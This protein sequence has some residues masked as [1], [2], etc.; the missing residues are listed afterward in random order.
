MGI[1]DS[2]KM[3]GGFGLGATAKGAEMTK[4]VVGFTGHGTADGLRRAAD[5]VDWVTSKAEEQ[6]DNVNSWAL[7]KLA[8]MVENAKKERGIAEDATA[9]EAGNHKVEV[10]EVVAEVKEKATEVANKAANAM[11][12]MKKR[13]SAAI[14]AA[15]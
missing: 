8:Q 9:I 14:T 1:F 7:G 6:C 4:A 11:E 10:E 5:G 2:V 12:D 13:M 3:I 15:A